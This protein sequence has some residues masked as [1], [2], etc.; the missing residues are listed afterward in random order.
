MK[1]NIKQL[2]LDI[3]SLGQLTSQLETSITIRDCYSSLMYA[4]AWLGK[5]L[6]E[7]GD[8][9]SPYKDGK[10]SVEDI[11]PT[12]DRAG[13]FYSI[14]NWESKNTI[15]KVDALRV[16]IGHLADVAKTLTDL[17]SSK[18]AAI[19]RT[20]AW[21]YLCEARFALGFEMGRIR[22]ESLKTKNS[23]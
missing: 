15:E 22:T 8:E 12:S 7:F 11:E 21:I 20:Q 3:D 14:D 5:L 4:K 1:Q 6:G 10:K 16:V 17:P 23:D 2:R 13:S 18:E 9:P 19:C